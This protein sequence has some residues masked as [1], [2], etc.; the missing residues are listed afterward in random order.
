MS[1]VQAV[2]PLR[3]RALERIGMSPEQEMELLEREQKA[4]DTYFVDRKEGEISLD[5]PAPNGLGKVG[6]LLGRDEEGQIV[7]FMALPANGIFDPS[8]HGSLYA[9]QR[10]GC[11]CNKCKGARAEYQR[12]YRAAQKRAA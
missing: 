1:A 7:C 9:Y 5:A 4:D 2:A 10:L 8:A 6:D 12:N 3:R 11:R